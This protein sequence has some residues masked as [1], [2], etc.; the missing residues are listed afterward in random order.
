MS[1]GSGRRISEIFSLY[2][3]GAE[4]KNT[5]G[6]DGK[7]MKKMTLK[8]KL[9]LGSLTLVVFVMIAIPWWFHILSTGKTARST[10]I[11]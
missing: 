10:S 1:P 5:H 6:K 7:G 3:R 4:E 2:R 8:N 9:I 11:S